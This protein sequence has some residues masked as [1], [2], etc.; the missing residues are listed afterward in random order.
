MDEYLTVFRVL[1]CTCC[2][3]KTN[4]YLNRPRVFLCPFLN[5]LTST[6]H[7]KNKSVLLPA[8]NNKKFLGFFWNIFS[9]FPLLSSIHHIQTL[10]RNRTQ[11]RPG[12]I[13]VLGQ[14]LGLPGRFCRHTGHHEATDVG[15]LRSVC[16]LHCP[17]LLIS[18]QNL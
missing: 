16:P 18:P 2:L 5:Y 10:P 8:L 13:L 6:S 7:L 11:R 3:S 14:L 9:L 17:T 4:S 15:A 1:L 12:P